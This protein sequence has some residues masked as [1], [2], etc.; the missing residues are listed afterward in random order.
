[1]CGRFTQYGTREDYLSYIH[2]DPAQRDI[3]YDPEPVSR[4]NV[5][6]GTKVLILSERNR[7]LHLDAVHW[8]YAPPWWHKPPL[9]NA[10]VETAAS[11]K[12]FRALWQHGR[13]IVFADGWY[14]WKREGNGKQPF[15]I[16]RQ[17]GQP[18]CMAAIGSTPF[19]RD[20]ENGGF[21][22]VTAPAGQGL[23]DIHD[24]RPLVL[25][26]AA[27][28]TWLRQDTP[29]DQA[30]EIAK[31]ESVPAECFRWHPVSRAVGNVKNQG[32]D[33]IRPL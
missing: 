26:P 25:P 2:A 24:R 10:R 17:D 21:V 23:I 16:H 1:M 22:V 9:I 15:F 18:L 8:G 12:M 32:E 13:A 5:A 4:Y 6:P 19:E 31:R 33:L 20:D 28:L 14:E 30:E 7:R 11:G 29:A 3:P 27:A